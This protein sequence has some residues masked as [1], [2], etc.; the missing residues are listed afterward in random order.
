MNPVQEFA[1]DFIVFTLLSI[2]VVYGIMHLAFPP[3][4]DEEEVDSDG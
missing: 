3:D 4:D 1:V 2:T